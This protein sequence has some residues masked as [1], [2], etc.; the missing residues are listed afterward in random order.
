MG[1]EALELLERRK[2]RIA[3]IEVNHEADRHQP[4]LEMIE[5]RAATGRIVERPAKCMLNQPA[6]VPL[7]RD[8]P[9]FLEADAEF[10]RLALGIEAKT[11]DQRLGEAAARALGEQCVFGAQ[12]H[13]AG[14]R[15][16]V[17]AIPGDAHVASG[18]AR[19]RARGIKQY[20]GGRKPRI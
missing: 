7:G 11:A 4:F 16:L 3:I 15:I 10:L 8:F 6:A 19:D 9:K 18:D 14:E 13:A 1:L 20:L 17:M 2:V 5:K 12:L